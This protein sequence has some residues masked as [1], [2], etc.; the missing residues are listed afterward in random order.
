MLKAM[1]RCVQIE[2]DVSIKL[3]SGQNL[4]SRSFQLKYR[5]W[6]L[7]STVLLPSETLTVEPDLIVALCSP[8]TRC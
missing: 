7:L 3:K 8:Q 4:Q 1:L 6:K 2:F 5:Q